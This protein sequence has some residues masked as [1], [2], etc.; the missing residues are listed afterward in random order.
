MNFL[1]YITA[2]HYERYLLESDIILQMSRDTFDAHLLEILGAVLFGG[3]CVLLRPDTGANLNL[4][5][6]IDVI[7]RHQ[8]TLMNLVPSLAVVL[9]DHLSNPMRSLPS[10]LRIVISSGKT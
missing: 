3:T 2:M 5:Y 9:V 10:S 6:L 8:V 4:V 7:E 1:Y